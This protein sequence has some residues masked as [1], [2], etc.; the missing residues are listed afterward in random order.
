MIKIAW[1]RSSPTFFSNA[2]KFTPHH[3]TV[4]LSIATPPDNGELNI[5]LSDTGK[6][7]PAEEQEHIFSPF[8]QSKNTMDDG[9]A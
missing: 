9:Q 2:F 4:T 6:G 5:S 3:G 7:I 1:K 8:Y